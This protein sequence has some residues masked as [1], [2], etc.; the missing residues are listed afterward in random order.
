MVHA[1]PVR[2]ALAVSAALV[3][4]ARA[5]PVEE[6]LAGPDATWERTALHDVLRDA[7]GAPRWVRPRW[8]ALAPLDVAVLPESPAV[9]PR[10]WEQLWVDAG[11]RQLAGPWGAAASCPEGEVPRRLDGTARCGTPV[12]AAKPVGPLAPPPAPAAGP[13]GAAEVM[14]AWHVAALRD[15][16][17]LEVGVDP[18]PP[19]TVHTSL[20]IANAFYGDLDGDGVGDVVTGEGE[21]VDFAHDADVIAHEV[22]HLVSDRVGVP[23]YD[24]ESPFGAALWPAAAQEGLADAWARAWTGDADVGEHVGAAFGL[25]ALRTLDAGWRCPDDLRGEPH[26]DGRVFGGVLAALAD[27]DPLDRAGFGKLLAAVAARPL[28]GPD[29]FVAAVRA[30]VDEAV[31]AGASPTLRMAAEDALAASQL[32]G[33]SPVVPWPLGL[34]R[35]LFA[36]TLALPADALAVQPS[37]LALAVR[38]PPGA[39]GVEVRVDTAA[40]A[41]ALWWRSGEP[42]RFDTA[43]DGT[44]G[45]VR[46]VAAEADGETRGHAG[47]D[48]VLLPGEPGGDLFLAVG[49]ADGSLLEPGFAVV[50]VQAQAAMAPRGCDTSGRRAVWGLALIALALRRR[51]AGRVT[52]T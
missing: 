31:E 34:A 23:G 49:V 33:C 1:R 47:G 35:G 42:V 18:G 4:Q 43:R 6:A 8:W 3:G 5:A 24:V 32:E 10:V 21:G 12:M 40:E 2:F 41:W 39:D 28:D 30:A 38:V 20:P 27:H 45:L 37:A 22:G 51:V 17:A 52:S 29:A 44:W 9:G 13:D 16:L 25:P 11:A 15:F 14:A 46:A 48:G 7:R 50:T 19:T 36:P 26:A